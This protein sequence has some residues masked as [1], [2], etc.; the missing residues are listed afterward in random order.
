MSATE[1]ENRQA[2]TEVVQALLSGIQEGMVPICQVN[3]ATDSEVLSA[4]LTAT[5]RVIGS[6][7]AETTPSLRPSVVRSSAWP[8]DPPVGSDG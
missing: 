5:R 8:P 6:I 4:L 1:M 3:R 2:R 7:L